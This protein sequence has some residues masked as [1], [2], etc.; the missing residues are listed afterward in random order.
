M[1]KPVSYDIGGYDEFRARATSDLLSANQKA[2]FPDDCRAGRSDEILVD[3]A[4]KLPAFATAGAR[5][6]DIGTGCGEL[7]Q[8]LIAVA[9]ERGQSL[10]VIDS[11]EVLALL[12]SGAHVEKVVGPFPACLREANGPAGRF[13]AIL[14]YSVLQYVFRERNVFDF[15]D[16]AS[17]L[18]DEAGA[19]LIGDI[20]NVGM[21]KRFLASASGKRYHSEHYPGLPE[22]DMRFNMPEPAHIDDAVVLGLLARARAA[23]LQAFVV[24][25]AP[26]LPMA[27]RREDLLIRRP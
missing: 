14:A 19:L 17:A 16:S 3:I 13:D 21:R 26:H 8:R 18:L 2:G 9:G 1:D 25:Q 4:G 15:V 11:A 5:I 7:A 12:P 6:L 10:T 20:P 27:G 22:P 24:P 23:G